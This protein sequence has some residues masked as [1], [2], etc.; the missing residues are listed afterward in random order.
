MTNQLQGNQALER[1]L[2]L[3]VGAK[4]C[5]RFT[6]LH[7]LTPRFRETAFYFGRIVMGDRYS[8][9]PIIRSAQQCGT[10]HR[11]FSRSVLV[12]LYTI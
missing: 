6:V 5:S 12:E 2:T 3:S 4:K 11:Q 1:N 10:C 7:I 8:R 9:V